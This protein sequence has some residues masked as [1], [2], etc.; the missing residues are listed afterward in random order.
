MTPFE[1]FLHRSSGICKS[2]EMDSPMSREGKKL[3]QNLFILSLSSG[4]SFCLAQKI[5]VTPNKCLDTDN[6]IRPVL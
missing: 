4:D 1:I 2:N 3:L 5:R 6:K